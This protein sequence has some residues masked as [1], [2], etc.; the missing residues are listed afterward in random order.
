M[1]TAGVPRR[2]DSLSKKS[3]IGNFSDRVGERSLRMT[4]SE[5]DIIKSVGDADL[6]FEA[7]PEIPSSQLRR[8]K[9]GMSYLSTPDAAMASAWEFLPRALEHTELRSNRAAVPPHPAASICGT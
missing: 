4:F 2:F 7:V 8:R 5:T 6:P 3:G 1:K 9:A